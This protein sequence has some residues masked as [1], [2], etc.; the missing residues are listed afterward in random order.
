MVQPIVP[1]MLIDSGQ[2]GMTSTKSN[3]HHAGT[4]LEPLKLVENPQSNQL[5]VQ[6]MEVNDSVNK[7][8]KNNEWVCL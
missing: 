8:N 6:Q 7:A 5:F 3:T 4:K 1:T 2:I